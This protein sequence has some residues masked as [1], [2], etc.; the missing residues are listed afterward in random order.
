ML[1]TT[2][3]NGGKTQ[4]L[5]IHTPNNLK[6]MCMFFFFL[7]SYITRK[8]NVRDLSFFSITSRCQECHFVFGLVG[9]HSCSTGKLLSSHTDWEVRGRERVFGKKRKQENEGLAARKQGGEVN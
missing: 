5:K 3:K 4:E 1:I 9:E 7:V 6:Y 8:Q 2:N